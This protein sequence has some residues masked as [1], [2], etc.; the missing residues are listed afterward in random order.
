MT[1]KK[2][3]G[4][5]RLT[6]DAADIITV[7]TIDDDGILFRSTETPKIENY[8]NSE[9]GREL[10]EAADFPEDIKSAV[11]AMWGSTPTIEMPNRHLQLI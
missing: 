11:M 7:N 8:V 3:Y 5:S 1:R 4:F 10:F 6:K 2:V 9:E